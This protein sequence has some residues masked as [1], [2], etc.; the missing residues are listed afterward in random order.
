[1]NFFRSDSQQISSSQC[2]S[3]PNIPVFDPSES[4]TAKASDDV[5]VNADELPA[6]ANPGRQASDRSEGAERLEP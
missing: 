4:A 2:W 1:M 5:A 3:F 6:S